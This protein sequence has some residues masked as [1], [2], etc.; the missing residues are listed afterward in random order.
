MNTII[1]G[2][3]IKSP[4]PQRFK[5]GQ[6]EIKDP[7]IIAH[8]FGEYFTNLVPSLAKKIPNKTFSYRFFLGNQILESCCLNPV[9][10]VEIERLAT[11]FNLAINRGSTVDKIMRDCYKH[12]FGSCFVK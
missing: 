10:I 2:R 5:D 11:L 1:T 9:L 6:E 12:C 3:K 8:K 4:I 7:G